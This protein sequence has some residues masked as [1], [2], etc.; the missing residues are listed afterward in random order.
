MPLTRREQYD[1]WFEIGEKAKPIVEDLSSDF[2]L[3]KLPHVLEENAII[4]K[5]LAHTFQATLFIFSR[6]AFPK[7]RYETTL[8]DLQTVT[9][10]LKYENEPYNITTTEPGIGPGLAGFII[11]VGLRRERPE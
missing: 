10:T 9:F 2:P 5:E 3:Q 4:S 7:R 6:R 1:R 8:E 11:G